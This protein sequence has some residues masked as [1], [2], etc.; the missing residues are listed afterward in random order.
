MTLTVNGNKLTLHYLTVVGSTLHGLHGVDSDTDV[1]GVFTWEQDVQMGLSDAPEQLDKSMNKEDR[2]DLMKQL[3]ENFG[4]EFDNDLDLFEAK[5]FFKNAMKTDPNM[6]DML[7]ADKV[8]GMVMY[9]TREFKAVLDNRHL[10]LNYE[11]AHKRFT[12]MSFN[13]LKLGK[14]ENNKNKFK[15][16]AKSLQSLFSFWNLVKNGSFNPRL[17]ETQTLTVLD[18]KMN[19]REKSHQDLLEEVQD[20]RSAFE[21]ECNELKLPVMTNESKQENFKKLNTML[22]NLRKV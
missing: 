3:S 12:G 15:D 18:V 14:K 10:F 11:L 7:N 5:K 20:F 21:E 13:C 19:L 9:C 17:N 1:K 16:L 8:Q 22:L 6:L 4:R 2:A